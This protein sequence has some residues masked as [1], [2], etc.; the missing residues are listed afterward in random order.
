MNSISEKQNQEKRVEL[1][2]TQRILYSQAKIYFIYRTTFAL[3][4][5]ILGPAL[6]AININLA[7]YIALVSIV[8]WLLDNLWFEKIESTK[9]IDAAKFQELFD[10]QVL[11]LNWNEVVVGS[12]PDHEIIGSIV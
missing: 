6:I 2:L 9:K 12:K 10:T 1:L 4:L 7:P 8:Y 11:D 5:A 3:I